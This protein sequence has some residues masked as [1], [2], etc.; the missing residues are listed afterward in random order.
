MSTPADEKRTCVLVVDDDKSLRLIARRLFENQ[1]MRVLEAADGATA[2]RMAPESRPDIIC[3]DVQMPGMDGFET[4]R[5]IRSDFPMLR[6]PIIF[7]S[8]LNNPEDVARGIGASGNDYIIK[9]FE[10]EKLRQRI[11]HWLRSGISLGD[12]I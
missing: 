2:L 4:C 7:V 3:L 5:R 11:T 9:P 6:V 1:G 10:P 12:D 8:S